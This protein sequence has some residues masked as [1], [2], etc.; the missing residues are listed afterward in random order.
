MNPQIVHVQVRCADAVELLDQLTSH[1]DHHFSE[2]APSLGHDAL[3]DLAP[4]ITGHRQMSDA[5]L[6]HLA[7]RL[8]L[9]LV[10]FDQAMASLSPWVE[11][12][13]VLSV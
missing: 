1:P 10:T 2:T 6:L 9:S 12:V 11:H 3:A 8:K 4:R 5:T 13:R 7:R